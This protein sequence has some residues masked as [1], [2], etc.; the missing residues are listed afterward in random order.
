VCGDFNVDFLLNRGRK[1][2]LSKLLGTV[3]M[4]S[5]VDFPTRIQSGHLSAIDNVFVDTLRLDSFTVIPLQ[6]ALSDH[7]A[8]FLIIT[9][10]FSKAT[11]NTNRHEN[12]P[13]FRL[14][15]CETIKNFVNE[16]S[17]ETWENIYPKLDV[18]GA[19]NSFILIFL[20]LIFPL[21]F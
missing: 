9:N 6:N 5:T 13:T 19:F 17:Y 1:K 4:I 2:Q 8:Q 15:N 18:N 12:K 3:N 10:F 14:I 7:D 21:F 20:K 16:L 11:S